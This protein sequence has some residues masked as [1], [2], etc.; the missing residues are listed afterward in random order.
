MPHR[1]DTDPHP[2]QFNGHWY[3]EQ[4]VESDLAVVT[5]E[6]RDLWDNGRLVQ[7]EHLGP[8]GWVP[9]REGGDMRHVTRV[10]WK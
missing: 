10:E 2:E 6:I 7:C 5:V 4:V 1:Y 3:R 8:D 9:H